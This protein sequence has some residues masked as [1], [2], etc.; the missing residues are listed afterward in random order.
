MLYLDVINAAG[1]RIYGATALVKD[2]AGRTLRVTI[3]KPLNEPG[4]NMP[5]WPHNLYR[6]AGVEIRGKQIP[7][8]RVSGLRSFIP[9]KGGGHSFL[10]IIQISEE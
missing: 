6:L 8:Q 2:A 9:G 5:M 1:K 3:E 7:A 10:V 4:G